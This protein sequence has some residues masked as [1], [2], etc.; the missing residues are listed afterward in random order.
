MGT[1]EAED[2]KV[3]GAMRAML[4]GKPGAVEQAKAQQKHHEA[5]EVD[6]AADKEE[7]ETQIVLVKEL[8]NSGKMDKDEGDSLIK[9]LKGLLED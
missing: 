2:A 1:E 3:A 6:V 7:L 8:M 5:R 4:E 9:Y